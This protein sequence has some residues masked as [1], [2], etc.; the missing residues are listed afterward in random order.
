MHKNAKNIEYRID[1]NGC[2]ICISH[3][4]IKGYARFRKNGQ[5]QLIHRYIYQ[6][7]FGSVG[8]DID[9]HHKCNNPGCINIAHLEAKKSGLHI[10]DHER[11]RDHHGESN[12]R[13]KL[14]LSQVRAIRKDGVHT[15]DQLALQY[16]VGQTQISRIRRGEQWNIGI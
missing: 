10:G 16:G 1:G 4:G 3:S 15:Q 9:I 11:I 13:H 2:F 8:V 6:L 7:V 5:K 14:T 12:N